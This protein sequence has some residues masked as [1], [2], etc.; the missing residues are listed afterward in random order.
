MSNAVPTRRLLHGAQIP[1]IGVG[2]WP[3]DDA[4]S[5]RVVADALQAGYRLVDTAENY[6]NETGVGRGLKAS[7][8]ER[9]EV[10]VTSKFNKRWHGK[11][12]VRPAA[13]RSLES[14]GL[15]YLDLLL[16]H[17]PNPS[18]D[19]Y[20]EAWEGLVDLL[21]SGLVKAIGT[22]NFKQSHLERIIA[23]TQV[24]PDV[25][26]IQLSP[27][28]TRSSVRTFHTEH[29]ILTESWSPIGG[30]DTEV[31]SA[32][33]VLEIARAVERTP[34]QVVLRWHVQL[35]LVP[36]PKSANP[37]RLRQNLQVFD[38][39]LSEQQVHELSALDQGESVVADS[40]A[41]GH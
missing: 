29:G 24:A 6:R 13:E 15:E 16:I 18:Q 3:L 19:R 23:A 38:F 36:I 22:S 40:D 12:L 25:N 35:G 11:D 17:W 1:A 37:E 20:L 41:F 8:V 31:L 26:Q 33:A 30:K 21:E 34:A 5:E 39:E 2:T 9:S 14:L 27:A 4:Q 7:G 10:F 32:P 28:A